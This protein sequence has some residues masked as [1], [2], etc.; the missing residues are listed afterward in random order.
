M[1]LRY[2]IDPAD[3]DGGTTAALIEQEAVDGASMWA[4][5]RADHQS[6][7]ARTDHAAKYGANLVMPAREIKQLLDQ[8]DQAKATIAELQL[9]RLDLG[10]YARTV[11]ALEAVRALHSPEEY[12]GGGPETDDGAICTHCLVDDGSHYAEYPCP[13]IRALDGGGDPQ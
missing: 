13:T 1:T 4:K 11:A 6:L 12:S 9:Q 3:T 10:K 5:T 8:L 2:S 7:R